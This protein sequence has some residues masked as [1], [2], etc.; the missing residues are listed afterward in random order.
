MA[1][2]SANEL[3]TLL[4]TAES[5]AAETPNGAVLESLLLQCAALGKD[6]IINKQHI[7]KWLKLITSVPQAVTLGL[8]HADTVGDGLTMETIAPPVVAATLVDDEALLSL[9]LE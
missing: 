5:T 6:I 4:T 1:D 2:G 9:Q 8:I 3:M 7:E